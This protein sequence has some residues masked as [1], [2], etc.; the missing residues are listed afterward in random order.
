M[1]NRQPPRLD[2]GSLPAI[3]RRLQLLRKALAPTQAEFCRRIGVA[4][5]A[6]N[7]YEKAFNR[8]NIDA[9]LRIQQLYG[10]PLDWIYIG[11]PAMLPSHLAEKVREI[12]T[13]EDR[14]G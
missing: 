14:A 13:A 10:V 7:N 2:P 9:A 5:N 4:P 6:W 3:A 1:T 11:I 8:I 12:E